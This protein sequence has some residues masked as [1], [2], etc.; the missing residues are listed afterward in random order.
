M[1]KNFVI[2][3]LSIV[4]ATAVIYS[5][6]QLNMPVMSSTTSGLFDIGSS[7]CIYTRSNPD[8]EWQ[9]TAPCSH[10]TMQTSGLNWVR[11]KIFATN[12]TGVAT[13]LALGNGT[14]GDALASDT[15]LSGLIIGC[16]LDAAAD[17]SPIIRGTGNMSVTKL[18]TSSCTGA[19]IVN[20]T[21]LQNNTG[22]CATTN[23]TL[24]S[25]KNFTSSVTLQNGDQ[26]NVTWFV[27]VS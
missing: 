7:V 24:F 3:V 22:F 15:S 20:A 23:C 21:A 18:W 17:A 12:G 11:D 5:T 8:D 6:V 25:T 9:L 16:G 2:A 26:L 1:N 19:L 4:L 27:W 13:V 10:N 14:N